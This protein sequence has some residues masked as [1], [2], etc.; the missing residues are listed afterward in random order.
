[1]HIWNMHISLNGNVQQSCAYI[2]YVQTYM[3]SY[4]EYDLYCPLAAHGK[5]V[6]ELVFFEFIWNMYAYINEII[7]IM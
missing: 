3:F 2:I 1:M 4:K 5:C 6:Y 7:G